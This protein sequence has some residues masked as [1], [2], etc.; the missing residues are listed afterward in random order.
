M[1]IQQNL[2]FHNQVLNKYTLFIFDF[3]GTIIDSHK[4]MKEALLHCYR[5]SGKLREPPYDLFFSM[6]GD[7]LNNI[8][9]ELGL[10]NEMIIEYKTFCVRNVHKVEVFSDVIETLSFLK[11]CQK[12]VA[13]FTGKDKE[14][15]VYLLN[16]FG[17]K[18]LFDCIVNPEDVKN[19]KPD[20]EGIYLLLKK[21]GVDKKQTIMIGDSY[22]DIQSAKRAN[23]DSAYVC[24]G[25]GDD[26]V[27]KLSPTFTYKTLKAFANDYMTL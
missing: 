8:F 4:L 12:Q 16:F 1:L 18:N 17:I 24:W 14:R 23:I 3:D 2:Y 7:S 21:L 13:L 6:M 25:T 9:F 22:Y 10:C 26:S 19:A 5:K 11:Q 27:Q 15:T 20:P